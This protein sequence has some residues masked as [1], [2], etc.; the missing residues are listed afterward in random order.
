MSM[1]STT[2]FTPKQMIDL[3]KQILVGQRAHES[4]PDDLLEY[5]DGSVTIVEYYITDDQGRRTDTLVKGTSCT[6][7][8]EIR[9][10][11]RLPAPVFAFTFKNAL[12]IE[13]TGTN[14]M[15]ERALLEGLNEGD[16]RHITFTQKLWLQGGEYLISF[17]ATGFEDGEFKVYHR[18][19]DAMSVTVVADKNTVGFF[20]MDSQV[21]VR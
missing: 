5:G 21:E 19:Y 9:V 8:M 6:I 13:I 17:G 4:G 14:T 11:R 16:K 20:D 2:S 3:Y 1:A 10:N 12:G 18:L 7:H 15:L